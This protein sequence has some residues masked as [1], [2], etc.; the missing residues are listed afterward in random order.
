MRKLWVLALVTV[1]A[2]GFFPLDL[3]AQKA[4]PP[5]YKPLVFAETPGAFAVY[6]DTRFGGN[7]YIGLCAMG[8]NQL[9]LRL[10]EPATKNELL[11]LQTFY[12]TPKGEKSG[13]LDIEPGSLDLIRGDFSA[14]EASQRLLPLVYNWLNAWLHSRTRFDQAHEFDFEEDGR[15]H[16]QYWV[17]VLQMGGADLQDAEANGSVS[18]VTAGMASSADDPAFFDYTGEPET[19]AGPK[20]SIVA[21]AARS[22]KVDGLA[23]PLDDNWKQDG[24][25]LYRIA[26]STP[27]DAYFMVETVNRGDFGNL[28]SFGLIKILL[29]GSGTTL[30]PDSLRVFASG[31][32][33]AVFYRVYDPASGQVSVQ[34]KLF[35]PRDEER[36]SIVSLG[37]FES[38]YADNKEYFDAILF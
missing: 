32:S 13:Q 12:T 21:S 2:T 10:Y 18:L 25:G 4:N 7:A 28:D 3:S 29:L 20:V 17:P 15:Y 26:Q 36:L 6:R 8:G 37:A 1:M 19:V 38:V 5:E 31:D 24:D 27:Q 11:V 33:P 14:S 35:V 22:V 23:F 34:Y 9:A 16:F 30:L